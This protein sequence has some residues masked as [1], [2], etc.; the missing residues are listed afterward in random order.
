MRRFFESLVGRRWLAW[1]VLALAIVVIVLSSLTVWVKRQALDTDNWVDVS[2]RLLENDDVR[3]VVAADLTDA[4][5]TNTD[6]QAQLQRALPPRFDTLAVP[7]TGLLRQAAYT[8][9]L[10]LLRSP[11]VQVLWKEANRRA[12]RNL[13]AVLD[14]KPTGVLTADRD[15]VVLDLRPLVAEL[16]RRVG[17]SVTLPPQAGLVTVLRSDQLGPAQDAVKIVRTLSVF[18]VILALALLA[19][20]IYLARGF[21]RQVLRATAISLIGVGVLLLV[22]RKIA[23]D[24]VIASITSPTTESAGL[25][26]WL[27]ATGLLHDVAVALIVYGVVLLIGVLLAGPSRGAT[28]VRRRLTPVM[29]DHL[30]VVYAAVA[31]L[32]VLFLAYGPGGGDRRLVG[33]IVLAALA[34]GGVEVLRRQILRESPPAAG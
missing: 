33:S 10:Q 17:L 7:A 9:A 4:L 21:R 8:S 5:F 25:T 28:A 27:I 32:F 1:T 20:A 24:Q 29:R 30:V 15:S 22:L 19:L 31:V 26:V 16:A 18:L 23:G 34:A 2:G 6:V 3:Q 11:S 14:G 12:H 13:I